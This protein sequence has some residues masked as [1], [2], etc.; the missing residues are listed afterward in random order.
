[1][2]TKILL[3]LAA[4]AALTACTTSAPPKF[5]QEEWLCLARVEAEADI[6][7][8]R[9]CADFGEACLA[10]IEEWHVEEAKK[11]LR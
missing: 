9:T 5:S 4:V 2:T 3:I 8:A 7:I 6:K 11:C 1:M 10:P